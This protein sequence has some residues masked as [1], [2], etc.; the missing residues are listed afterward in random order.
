MEA[1]NGAA[2]ANV[3]TEMDTQAALEQAWLEAWFLQQYWNKINLNLA[4]DKAGSKA[5]LYFD[6]KA[7]R[8]GNTVDISKND[9]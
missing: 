6:L 1:T 8:D 4:E 2:E 7:D 9:A 3:Q 5:K